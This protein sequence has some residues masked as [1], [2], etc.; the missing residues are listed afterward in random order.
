MRLRAQF[1]ALLARAF[2]VPA[3]LGSMALARPTTP[4]PYVLHVL[5]LSGN[6]GG[7]GYG[8]PSA[9]VLISE[10]H[11][12]TAVPIADLRRLFGLTEREAELAAGMRRVSASTP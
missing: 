9:A 7:K 10:P 2:A 11:F 1:S 12:G 3:V 6:E 5:P 4:Q 8:H